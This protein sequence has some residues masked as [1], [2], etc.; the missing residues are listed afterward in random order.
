MDTLLRTKKEGRVSHE[1]NFCG[2]AFSDTFARDGHTQIGATAIYYG[3]SLVTAEDHHFKM[4]KG[5]EPDLT[6][7][8][9]YCRASPFQAAQKEW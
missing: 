8:G 2:A 1:E 9:P 6:G 7:L 4:L 3:F 5:L